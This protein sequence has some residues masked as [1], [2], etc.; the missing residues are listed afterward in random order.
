MKKFIS[1]LLSGAIALGTAGSAPAAALGAAPAIV[2]T[3][4]DSSGPLSGTMNYTLSGGVLTITGTGPM[5]NFENYNYLPWKN[6]LG[7]I[8]SVVIGEGVTT[9]GTGSFYNCSSLSSVSVPSTVTDVYAKAF[10][11]CTSLGSINL[12]NVSNIATYAFVGCSGLRSVYIGNA[13]CNIRVNSIPPSATIYGQAGSTAES[14]ARS[15]KNQFVAG[16]PSGGDPVPTPT[17]PPATAPPTTTSTTT[18]TTEPVTTTQPAPDKIEVSIEKV[19]LPSRTTY[20]VGETPV[21]NDGVYNVS[22]SVVFTDGHVES[23]SWRKDQ[24]N[25]ES[26]EDMVVYYRSADIGV[27]L[28]FKIDASAVNAQVPG[29]YPVYINVESFGGNVY[30]QDA[31]EVTINPSIQPTEAPTEPPTQAPTEPPTEEPTQAPTEAPTEPSTVTPWRVFNADFELVAPP[32]KTT[33]KQG[34]AI[35]GIDL[36]GMQFRVAKHYQDGTGTVEALVSYD[37][38]GADIDF[39]VKYSPSGLDI[40]T[41]GKQTVS[42]Y[43]RVSDTKYFWPDFSRDYTTFTYE[44]EV[45]AAAEQPTS[46]IPEPTEMSASLSGVEVVLVTPPTKRNYTIDEYNNHKDLSGMQ[47]KITRRYAEGFSKESLVSYDQHGADIDFEVAYAFPQTALVGLSKSPATIKMEVQIYVSDV[48][49][50]NP[51]FSAGYVTFDVEVTDE[52]VS[53][54][55]EEY[56]PGDINGDGMVDS[57]DATLLLEEYARTSTGGEPTFTEKQKKAADVDGNGMCDSADASG[58]LGYYAYL[59]T[60][61]DAPPK[62]LKEI[63]GTA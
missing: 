26:R 20:T 16:T 27:P 24:S 49:G 40:N 61:S 59:Q 18:T 34:E 28:A 25:L 7:S 52:K 44:V 23:G 45:E 47:V 4:G 14:Y 37:Q 21:L 1:I 31:F 63:L 9:I 46:E 58:I 33:Y 3:V 30:A 5:P 10:Q 19:S 50:T 55:V 53:P 57:N 38:H 6:E 22:A 12:P 42:V 39:D 48:K 41:P 43:V 29:K 32:S 51:S 15:N 56:T 2:N 62:S 35:D 8:R 36:S 11:S 60:T 13:S 54:P 17:E